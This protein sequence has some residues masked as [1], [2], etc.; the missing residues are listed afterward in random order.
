M[1][2]CR[3]VITRALRKIRVYGA[4]EPVS[5]EDMADGLTELQNLYHEWAAN[6]MFGTLEDVLTNG[7]YEAA[8]GER[9]RITGTDEVILPEDVDDGEFPPY[10][11]SLIEIVRDDNEIERH[12]YDRGSWVRIDTLGLDDT[13]PLAH[14]GNLESALAMSLAEDHGKALGPLTMRQA[15]SFIRGLSAKRGSDAQVTAADWF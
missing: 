13:A 11:L 15:I 1:A 7:E 3:D 2:T 12:L 9:I 14:R 6:G 4:G 10:D 5:P 8:P